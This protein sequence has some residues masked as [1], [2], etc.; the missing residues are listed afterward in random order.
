MSKP[1]AYLATK[2]FMVIYEL[3]WFVR[4]FIMLISV[5]KSHAANVMYSRLIF[6]SSR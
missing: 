6:V 5:I 1:H 4:Q 2:L 3:K